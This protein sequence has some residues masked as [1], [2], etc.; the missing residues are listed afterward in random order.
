MKLLWAKEKQVGY[1]VTV[2]IAASHVTEVGECFTASSTSVEGRGSS[3]FDSPYP[4][5]FLSFC[6]SQ[7]PN[8]RGGSALRVRFPVVSE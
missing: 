2:N 7:W 5:I 3:G 6:S 1:G 8:G 4:K